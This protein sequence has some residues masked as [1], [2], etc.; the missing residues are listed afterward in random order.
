MLGFGVFEREFQA[1]GAQG[2]L[3]VPHHRS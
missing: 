2:E 3:L 1:I